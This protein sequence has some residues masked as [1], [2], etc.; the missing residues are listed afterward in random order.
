MCAYLQTVGFGGVSRVHSDKR[1]FARRARRLALAGFGLS[2][3]ATSRTV[4]LS[5][6]YRLPLP[7]G[8]CFSGPGIQD[9]EIKESPGRTCAQLNRRQSDSQIQLAS[10]LILQSLILQAD[11]ILLSPLSGDR[12]NFGNCRDSLPSM[13]CAALPVNTTCRI[14]RGILAAGRSRGP[15]RDRSRACRAGSISATVFVH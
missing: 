10:R 1:Q 12:D 11:L 3:L 6:R 9:F 14:R 8:A 2:A 13:T 4:A 5:L 7:A 15:R